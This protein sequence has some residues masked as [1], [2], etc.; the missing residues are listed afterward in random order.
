MKWNDDEYDNSRMSGS[1]QMMAMLIGIVLFTVVIFALVIY[2]NRYQ[3]GLAHRPGADA[4]EAVTVATE[5]DEISEFVS[6]ETRTADDLDIWNMY[7]I[8]RETE[9]VD[10]AMPVPEEGREETVPP[11]KDPATDGKHTKVTLRDGSEEWVT[12]NNYLKK[13]EIDITQ[14]TRTGEFMS[15][16]TDGRTS[17][18]VGVDLSKY[19][20]YVDFQK[21]K[22]AGID[23]VM[24]KVGARGYESGSM[25]IDDYYE[26]NIKRASDAGLEIGLYFASQAITEDEA[27][28]EANTVLES[29]GD[30]DVTYPIAIDL[31][32][33]DGDSCRTEALIPES[34][35]AIAKAFCDTIAEAG[36]V[37]MIYADK[38]MLIKE[39]QLSKLQNFDIWLCNPGD[40]PDYPYR[41]SMWQYST[42][43]SIDGIS[44]RANMNI[45]FI[46]FTVK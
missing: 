33:V 18:Y 17:S 14:L 25:T 40:T 39:L 13:S 2:L 4:S 38:E 11:E 15:Y 7:P 37:P 24:L 28:E 1:S 5:E 44:G 12:I 22:N 21:L 34:R 6:G 9:A 31:E 45:S 3:L 19:N 43:A 36:Y 32:F 16:N 42:S 29:I 26:G 23:F 20:D 10:D 30:Y 41:F 8:V 27:I 35:T 46:D